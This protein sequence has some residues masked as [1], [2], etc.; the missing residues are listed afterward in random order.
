MNPIRMLCCAVA[1]IVAPLAASASPNALA[2]LWTA[3]RWF[4]PYARGPLVIRRVGSSYTADMVGHEVPIRVEQGE[5][6]FDLPGKQ[7]TFRGKFAGAELQGHW[8]PGREMRGFSHA[9]PV[10]LKSDGSNRWSGDVVP[11]DDIFTFHLFVRDGQS[12]TLEAFLVNPEQDYG[13]LLNVTRLV[14]EG[15]TVK[16]LGK[17]PWQKAVGTVA[18]G[19]YDSET[20]TISLGFP[21]RGGTYDFHRDNDHSDFYTRGKN[22]GKYVYQPPPARD[23]GWPVGTLEEAGIDRRGI[24]RLVQL[25]LDAHVDSASTPKVHGLLIV[26]HGKLVLEEYF[27]GEHRDKLHETRSAAKSAV[28]VLVGAALRNKAPLSLSTPVY[29]LMNGGTFPPDLD[30]RKRSMTLETL[31]TMSSGYFCDDT[32]DDAPGNEDK[33]LEQEEEP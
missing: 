6:V 17:P 5:L 30:P 11:Y 14:S 2:G 12:D 27:H 9:T 23:D 1:L 32:N 31:L 18:T 22:P 24:E 10:R 28:A 13:G 29:Q 8:Y 19:T 26:R 3:K 7:G 4:G 33:M 15:D 21:A 25:L 16:L 20:G